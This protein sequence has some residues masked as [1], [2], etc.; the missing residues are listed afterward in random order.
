MVGHQTL[1][2]AI[3]VRVPASQPIKSNQIQEETAP[4]AGSAD[5]LSANALSLWCGQGKP[6]P[7]DALS[8]G[9]RLDQ[10]DAG[11]IVRP[12]DDCG[13]GSRVEREHEARLAPRFSSVQL[14]AI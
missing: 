5:F 14:I 9:V 11:R 10:A 6:R 12:A 8:D 3:G 1:N 4:L 2:L 13:V 7:F